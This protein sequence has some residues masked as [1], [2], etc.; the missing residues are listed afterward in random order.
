[1]KS[2]DERGNEA[3]S[4]MCLV[5]AFGALQTRGAFSK[6]QLTDTQLSFPPC[7]GLHAFFCLAH[8]F[9]SLQVHFSHLCVEVE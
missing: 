8:T 6:L 5:G 4:E 2:Q 1:M 7:K 9:R 3:K